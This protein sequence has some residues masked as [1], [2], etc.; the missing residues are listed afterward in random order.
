MAEQTQAAA[1]PPT[2]P[3]PEEPTGIF[4]SDT[5]YGYMEPPAQQVME[6]ERALR[7][8]MG[9]DLPR[10]MVKDLLTIKMLAPEDSRELRIYNIPEAITLIGQV[11]QALVMRYHHS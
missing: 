2:A 1:P 11:A 3:G 10:Q 4:I 7:G 9:G 6:L 8:Q 5:I